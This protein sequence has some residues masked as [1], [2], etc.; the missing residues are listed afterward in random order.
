MHDPLLQ[1]E[2]LDM[3]PAQLPLIVAFP[4]LIICCRRKLVV[5]GLPDL[6]CRAHDPDPPL[7]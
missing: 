7:A 4:E 5:L 3:Q 1:L 2:E 6:L